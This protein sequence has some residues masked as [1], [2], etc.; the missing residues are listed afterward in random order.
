MKVTTTTLPQ[1]LR[2]QTEAARPP[3]T[4]RPNTVALDT[5]E[6]SAPAALKKAAPAETSFDGQLVGADG[7]GHPASTPLSEI[8]PVRPNNGK[9]PTGE[10]VVYVNG[11]SSEL[12]NSLAEA[13]Q[14][15]NTTGECVINL[16]NATNGVMG[17][18][19]QCVG[20]YFEKGQNPAV[21]ALTDLLYQHLKD[22]QPL[23]LV[24]HS[25]GT[26]I[27]SRALTNAK[28]L[29]QR[30]GLTEQ[31][32]EAKMHSLQIETFAS[33]AP[34]F[35][36]GPRYV[37]YLDDADPV[38]R[39]GLDHPGTHAGAGAVIHRYDTGFDWLHP[40]GAHNIGNYLEHWQP[41]EAGGQ[42][43]AG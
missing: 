9:T 37:H 7:V 8:A 15:A 38:A 4:A 36:D 42:V 1:A 25:Q 6:V 10:T 23:H 40:L 22:G 39:L 18:L 14:L 20:D 21:D 3:V 43:A 13:Q 35:P 27:T 30:D 12:S 28:L 32:A 24:A 19:L 16:H 26:M 34:S 17:D 29:L 2:V 31:Q 5:F 41:L 33:A 11:V